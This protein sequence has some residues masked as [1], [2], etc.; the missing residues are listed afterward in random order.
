[1]HYKYLQ[2]GGQVDANQ[3]MQQVVSIIETAGQELQ[4]GEVGKGVQTLVQLLQDQQGQEIISQVVQQIP[5]L[6][7]IV[8]A[9]AQEVQAPQSAEKGAILEAAN[10]CKSC[11][12]YKQLMRRGGKLIEVLV[13]CNG[14]PVIKAKKGCKIRKG[15]LG[16]GDGIVNQKYIGAYLTNAPAPAQGQESNIFY[17]PNTKTLRQ[18]VYSDGAWT[19]QDFGTEKLA[20]DATD[21]DTS[22]PYIYFDQA[23][24]TLMQQTYDP[25]KG[26]QQD[27]IKEYA[28]MP[29][30]FY[31]KGYNSQTG[32][33]DTAENAIA[34]L[35]QQKYNSYADAAPIMYG[36]TGTAGNRAIGL[37]AAA[38]NA[39]QAMQQLGGVRNALRWNRDVDRSRRR[40]DYKKYRE[41]LRDTYSPSFTSSAVGNASSATEVRRQLRKQHKTDIAQRKND[42]TINQM[43]LLNSG[44]LGRNATTST[45]NMQAAGTVGSPAQVAVGASTQNTPT[46]LSDQKGGEMSYIKPRYLTQDNDPRLATSAADA[47]RRFEELGVDTPEGKAMYLMEHPVYG[48]Q[49]QDNSGVAG[50]LYK[51]N[52]NKYPDYAAVFNGNLPFNVKNISPA[53]VAVGVSK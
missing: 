21:Q 25:N 37:Q 28:G 32:V 23:T 15:R 49:I 40:A 1:M 44:F 31:A 13:D 53:Q 33:F 22:K 2:Q 50:F 10:G 20:K 26:W 18:N 45:I 7:Q 41:S 36:V 47:S 30:D 4:K 12:N 52:K 11:R 34:A 3:V 6:G 51:H 8:E 19:V 14:V 42:Y 24:G 39:E 46:V 16:L 48:K 38:P 5:E 9:V 43:K 29:E 27:N 35:G 17:D